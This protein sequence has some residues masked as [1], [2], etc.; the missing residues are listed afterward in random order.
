MT[1][2]WWSQ[3]FPPEGGQTAEG[4]KNQLGR[5]DL[6]SYSILVREAVQ[7]CWD[8]R[9]GDTIDVRFSIRHLGEHADAWREYLGTH[10]GDVWHSD[11]LADLGPD[12]TILV[13]SDRRTTG[14]GGPVRSDEPAHDGVPSNFVQFIRNVGE[15]RDRELGGGTYGFGKG[16]FYRVSRA[17]AILVETR[18]T[19]PGPAQRR[20]MGA[21]LG[22]TFT[23]TEGVRYTGRHWWGEVNDGIPD[24]LLGDD[25]ATLSRRLGLP[26][27]GDSET[28]T[29]V[30]VVCPDLDLDE[31]DGDPD[32]LARSI[33]RDIYWHL[34]P[35]MVKDTPDQAEDPITFTVD[36]DGRPLPFPEIDE[37][38]VLGD[39]C[40]SLR[41]V[42]NRQG[43][44]FSMPRYSREYGN[45]GHFAPQMVMVLKD[46][47]VDET[48]ADILEGGSVPDVPHHVA[49]MRQ[50]ELVVDYFEGMEMSTPKFGYV[51]VFKVS[52]SGD[53][54]FAASEPPT[55]DNWSTKGL[56]GSNLGI[57]RR[58]TSWLKD[59]CQSIAEIQTATRS[60]RVKGLG[61]V[62]MMLGSVVQSA[63]DLAEAT[64]GA[65]GTGP[66][67]GR[68]RKKR[69]LRSGFRV[70]RSSRVRMIDGTP[71]V[72]TS[73]EIG[74]D[75]PPLVAYA[76]VM[77]AGNHME[78]AGQAPYGTARP[79]V[80]GWIHRPT[81]RRVDG[82][83]LDPGD[84]EPGE[85]YAMAD[86]LERVALKVT[87]KEAPND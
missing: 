68:N 61:R 79:V 85:W 58:A 24:P 42:R 2:R 73:V 40:E 14:L 76:N 86:L 50:A 78:S 41:K 66:K 54:F 25:A 23:G 63:G 59:K 80:A 56:T 44:S 65:G 51:G 64:G 67:S 29:D 35:K 71:M 15:P 19:E 81:G 34:W 30:V 37:I 33:R 22:G 31:I 16:I 45:F 39:F 84:S 53:E 38:P 47:V 77:L 32:R 70:S 87:V 20:L 49:R 26:G 12:S 9:L 27:F 21:S 7:N 55:H 10:R 17:S 72:T 83:R 11:V 57:V 36:V 82:A 74:E 4:I 62:A 6:S 46:G 43:E 52:K 13:I 5:P 3:P 28:G 1:P 60:K 18:N 48:V 75:A 8:A 69:A